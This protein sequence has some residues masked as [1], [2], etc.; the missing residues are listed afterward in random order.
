MIDKP[1]YVI[2]KYLATTR[3][4]EIFLHSQYKDNPGLQV[5][6]LYNML[7]IPYMLRQKTNMTKLEFEEEYYFD[8]GYVDSR[9]KKHNQKDG[10]NNLMIRN[11]LLMKQL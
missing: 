5:Q 8:F 10:A 2:W 9:G 1:W 6:H 7:K 11:I 3:K 4:Q